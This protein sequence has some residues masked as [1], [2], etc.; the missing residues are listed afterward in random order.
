MR[1]STRLAL[2]IFLN[3]QPK[4]FFIIIINYYDE[5]KKR[6][7]CKLKRGDQVRVQLNKDIFEKGFTQNWSDDIFTVEAAFQK[8]GLCWYR[9]KDEQGNIYPKYNYFY[10]LNKV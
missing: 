5:I 4:Q 2:K 1:S 7:T 6:I 8:N 9:I 3:K 10:E